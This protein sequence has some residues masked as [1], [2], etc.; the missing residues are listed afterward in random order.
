ML[1]YGIVL[2]SDKS[3]HI[4][5]AFSVKTGKLLAFSTN[6]LLENDSHHAEY[7]VL[8]KLINRL[9][10]NHLSW[11]SVRNRIIL[12]V[13]KVKRTG[14]IKMSRPC[15]RCAQYIWKLKHLIKTVKWSNANA[16]LIENTPYEIINDKNV[17]RSRGDP[18]GGV[19]PP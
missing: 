14:I 13:I 11:K 10:N 5:F 3:C 6:H 18:R 16:E 1:N 9:N 17:H 2:K 4:S 8:K 7:L 15:L 12:I 19:P